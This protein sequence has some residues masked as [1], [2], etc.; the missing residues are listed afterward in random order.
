[1][2]RPPTN[3]PRSLTRTVSFRPLARL[4]TSTIEGSGRVVCAAENWFRSK[5][6]PFAVAFIWKASPY[7]EAMPVWS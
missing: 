4:V 3:G 1:M 7:H 6:S 5:I 2:I